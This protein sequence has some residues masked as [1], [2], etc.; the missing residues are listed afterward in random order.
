MA[1]EDQE[2]QEIL[3]R[4]REYLCLL[5][6]FQLSPQLQAKLDASDLVQQTLLKAHE[7]REQFRGRSTAELMGWLR[8]ILANELAAALRSFRTEARDL[9]REH[10]LQADLDASSNRLES[11]LATDQTSP[12]QR[13]IRQ[14]QLLLLAQALL[15]LPADQRQAVE[16][17]HFQECSLAEVSQRMG[18]SQEAVVGLLYRGLKKLRQRLDDPGTA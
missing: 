9:A 17:H 2:R 14:E 6:R 18:R 13:A 15:E 16:L 10:S 4:C 1:P 8:Q 7:K 12:S 5:A 11:W 3:E